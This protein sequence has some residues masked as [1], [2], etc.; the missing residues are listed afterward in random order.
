MR[1][2]MRSAGRPGSLL[3]QASRRARPWPGGS[4]RL[5][6]TS[7]G[8]VA[9]APTP[10]ATGHQLRG[11]GSAEGSRSL[12]SG[13]GLWG[14]TTSPEDG[15]EAAGAPGR[16]GS[17]LGPLHRVSQDEDSGQ[18]TSASRAGVRGQ[19]LPGARGRGPRQAALARPWERSR[20]P[21]PPAPAASPCP[22]HTETT[23]C[24]PHAPRARR[25][26]RGAWV[27]TS[28]SSHTGHGSGHGTQRDERKTP[29]SPS[30]GCPQPHDGQRAG[31]WGSGRG[32]VRSTS[33][34]TRPGCPRSTGRGGSSP[35]A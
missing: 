30:W 12:A 18:R 16:R 34:R 26:R 29:R 31:G 1:S 2:L 7:G 15:G 28:A 17:F 13:A 3:K 4:P 21:R 27:E 25:G 8:C 9:A 11:G 23:A 19:G 35:R 33:R 24:W 6:G 14:V 22:P 32:G 20:T 10:S 5:R